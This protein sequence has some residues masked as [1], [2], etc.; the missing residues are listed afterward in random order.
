M[1][2]EDLKKG[3]IYFSSSFGDINKYLE[4][5][6]VNDDSAEVNFIYSEKNKIT[7]GD[8]KIYKET[9]KG[10]PFTYKNYNLVTKP[11]LRILFNKIFD[12]DL[13]VVGI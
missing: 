3:Q 11:P 13:R 1:E 4:I 6:S 10:D 9:I 8:T 12:K 2:I 7:Y 5:V